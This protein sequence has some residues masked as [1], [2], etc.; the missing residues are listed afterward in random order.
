MDISLNNGN[1]V[2]Q[3]TIDTT[4]ATQEVKVSYS[5]RD[6]EIKIITPRVA[7]LLLAI[8]ERVPTELSILPPIEEEMLEDEEHRKLVKLYTDADGVP[9][10]ATM[11]QVK[12]L[13]TKTLFVDGLT[14]K[15][16]NKL[17]NGDIISLK[18]D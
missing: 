1:N 4:P 3:I 15:K 9:C 16:I 12:Q 11:E 14:D 5:Q 7:D 10:Y 13:G 18:E 6:Q 8:S 2:Q 17:S